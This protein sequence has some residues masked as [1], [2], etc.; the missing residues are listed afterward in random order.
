MGKSSQIAKP[1][2]VPAG[3]FVTENRL[4]ARLLSRRIQELLLTTAISLI[5][6]A[7]LTGHALAVSVGDVITQTDGTKLTVTEV[8]PGAYVAVDVSGKEYAI[9]DIPA[10]NDTLSLPT[11]Q[12]QDGHLV[13][14][15]ATVTGFTTSN[16]NTV[17][18]YTIVN[19][20]A[21]YQET[22]DKGNVTATY[23]ITSIVYSPTINNATTLDVVTPL[24]PETTDSS[25]NSVPGVGYSDVRR[26]SNG[27]NGRA[28]ALFVPATSGKDGTDGQSFSTTKTVNPSIVAN[29]PGIVIAS[30]GGNGGKGGNSYLG[31]GGKPGGDA[32]AGGNV[33]ATV[34]GQGSV[35]THGDGNV[36]IAVQSRAGVGGKGGTGYATGGGGSGGTASHGGSATLDNSVN[37][38]TDGKGAHG[39]LVQSLGGGAGDGGSS[40][41]LFGD[42]GGSGAG[43]NGGAVD[44]TNSGKITT[45]GDGAHGIFGQSI[46]GQG[47]DGGNAVGIVAF[48]G[49]SGVG[50]DGGS[51]TIA[52]NGGKITTSGERSYGIFGQSVGGSGGTAGFNAGLVALGADAGSGGNGGNVTISTTVLVS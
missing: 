45:T 13:Y 26:A 4:R 33:V 27:K 25:S 49:G 34:N 18:T 50:G 3:K 21:V 7:G 10:V 42:A 30:I 47:G 41:G 35:T 5:P 20:Q 14:A 28:G 22:D 9:L 46:G 29:G 44:I 43:G 40:Y 11:G 15:T 39:I 23:P 31:T 32:G 51:V 12:D 37:V 19:G 17:T 1:V 2:A 6:L 36:G 16:G 48:A 52:N 24:E 38:T 8:N